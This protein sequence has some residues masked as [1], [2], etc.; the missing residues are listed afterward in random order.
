MDAALRVM[1]WQGRGACWSICESS[2][3]SRSRSLRLYI[4]SGRG[5][6]TVWR[7]SARPRRALRLGS[8]LARRGWVTIRLGRTLHAGRIRLV[9]IASGRVVVVGT[10][11]RKPTMKAE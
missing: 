2:A 9:L 10:E 8:A 7:H 5:R 4:K 1:P 11:A 6:I 3:R